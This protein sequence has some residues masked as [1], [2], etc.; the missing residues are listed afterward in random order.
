MHRAKP[1]YDKQTFILRIRTLEHRAHQTCKGQG[2]QNTHTRERYSLTT[3][4][5]VLAPLNKP[6]SASATWQCSA[7][8]TQIQHNPPAQ[9]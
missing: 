6:T 1:L 4:L 5:P 9:S 3:I 8:A 2:T 7:R